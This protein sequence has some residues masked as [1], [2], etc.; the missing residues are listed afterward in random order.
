VR[1]R[2]GAEP[3]E[4]GSGI[5]RCADGYVAMVAGR[6]GTARAWQ[7]LVEW[8]VE[9]GVHGATELQDEWWSRLPNRQS[10]RGI[11]SFGEVFGLYTAGRTRAELYAEAQRRGIALSPVNDIAAVLADRQLAARDFWVAVDDGQLGRKLTYPGPPYRLTAT[12]ARAARAA[13]RIG[14][15]NGQVLRE[16]LGLSPEQYAQLVE[17]GTV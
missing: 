13:P 7:S 15:H 6:L 10:E 11:T 9:E 14:E 3:R 1:E 16:R 12:P 17:A 5:Y 2:L 4:A 8:L